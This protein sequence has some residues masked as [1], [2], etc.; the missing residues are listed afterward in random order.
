MAAHISTIAV[1][2]FSMRMVSVTLTKV[3]LGI[4]LNAAVGIS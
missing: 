2:K 3:V 4:V 1:N